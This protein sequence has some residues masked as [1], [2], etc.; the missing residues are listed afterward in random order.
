MSSSG[1]LMMHCRCLYKTALQT[2]ICQI[3]TTAR[4]IN[5]RF[6][7]TIYL[8]FSHPPILSYNRTKD[9]NP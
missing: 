1:R 9:N 8:I 2:R 6:L 5:Q 3:H 4:D 7:I